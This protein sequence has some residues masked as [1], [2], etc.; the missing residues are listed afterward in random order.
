MGEARFAGKKPYRMTLGVPASMLREGA[1]ELALT[2]VAD[3]GATSYVFLDRFTL[4]YPQASLLA[5]GRFDGTWSDAGTVTLAGVA[6]QAALLDVTTSGGARWLR[7][8]E[9]SGGALR[10]RAEAG[11][12]YLAV[13]SQGLLTP[14]VATPAASSLRATTSQADY[15][16]IAPRAFLA[17]A[18]P[19]LERRRDQGL[20]ARGVAFEEIADAFG[21]GQPSAEA[22]HSFLAYAFRGSW[23]R[24]SPRYVLLLG[25][26]S[27]DP[28]NFMG[29][30]PPSPLPALWTKTSYLW[31][32]SDPLLAAVNGDDALPDLAIG[33]LPAATVEEAQRLVAKLMAWED[34]GQG[35]SGAAALVADNPDLGG[36]FEADVRDIAGSFLTGKDPQ[37]LLLSELG[38][39]ARPR[40]RPHSTR[41]WA[42]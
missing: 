22:I 20:A 15:L 17:A 23:T 4:S 38:E 36:D 37:L 33:R 21:H 3:T 6:G 9:A 24:P 11:H 30:S 5:G 8:Y 14:R 1:N 2:N 32:A 34:S 28:R 35:F 25:D 13:S 10:F 41:A 40:S 26:S 27:Y 7:G 12:R 31:T 16:L 42:P 19:L 39:G 18:E 29:T